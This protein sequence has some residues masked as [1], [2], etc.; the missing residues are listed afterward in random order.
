MYITM[1]KRHHFTGGKNVN[2][3][4]SRMVSF[5]MILQTIVLQKEKINIFLKQMIIFEFHLMIHI[6]F[7]QPSNVFVAVKVFELFF[8]MLSN[9]N[10]SHDL[11]HHVSFIKHDAFTICS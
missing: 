8:H 11:F 5:L 10:M 3:Q 1:S 6:I 9:V 4:I 2:F 7:G